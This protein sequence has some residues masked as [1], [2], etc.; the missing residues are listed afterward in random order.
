MSA[1]IISL[2]E[3]KEKRRQQDIKRLTKEVNRDIQKAFKNG[4]C[5]RCGNDTNDLILLHGQWT[6]RA[7]LGV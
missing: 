3:H 5:D 1:K 7:C 6:C 4:M 2:A